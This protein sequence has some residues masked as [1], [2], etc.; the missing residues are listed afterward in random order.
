[1]SVAVQLPYDDAHPNKKAEEYI[2]KY[3]DNMKVRV[4]WGTAKQFADELW[5]RWRTYDA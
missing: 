3:F 5:K 4:Y 2:T 1:M